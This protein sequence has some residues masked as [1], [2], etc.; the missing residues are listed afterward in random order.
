[1]CWSGGCLDRELPSLTIDAP[2]VWHIHGTYTA[3]ERVAVLQRTCGAYLVV[4][5]SH[6]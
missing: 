6:Y 5:G 2:G 1:M 3:P 4:R